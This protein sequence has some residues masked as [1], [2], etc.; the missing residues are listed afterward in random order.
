VAEP[1]TGV[2]H[3]PGTEH[4]VISHKNPVAKG[5]MV[6]DLTA[7]AQADTRSQYRIGSDRDILAQCGAG[8][9]ASRRVYARTGLVIGKELPDDAHQCIVGIPDDDTG[10]RST[11]CTRQLLGEKHCGSARAA[12]VSGI[13]GGYRQGQCLGTGPIQRP[14]RFDSHIPVAKQ[15]AT[16]KVGDRLR[17]K[18]SSRHATSCPL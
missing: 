6:R 15:A 18:A 14:D 5:G 7:I 10:P 12:E 16:D 3:R 9:N 13:A 11:G 2:A 8:A 1:R 4:H 17:G